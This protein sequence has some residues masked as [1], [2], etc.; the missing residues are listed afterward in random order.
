ML[1]YRTCILVTSILWWPMSRTIISVSINA[2]A[3]ELSPAGLILSTLPAGNASS[4]PMTDVCNLN[5]VYNK[6]FYNFTKM[7]LLQFLA[8]QTPC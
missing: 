1:P 2:L 6:I 5:T 8:G 3:I 7:L 4:V